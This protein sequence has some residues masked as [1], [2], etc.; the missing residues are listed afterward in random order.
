RILYIRA[1]LDAKRY[2]AYYE[3]GREELKKPLWVM[4][5]SGDLLLED[6][7]AQELFHELWKH[8]HCVPH[9][10]ENHHTLPPYGGTKLD[11]VV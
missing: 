9:N 3:D 5:Y 4:Y 6:A 7:E 8:Y 1:M 11:V 10:G 2:R